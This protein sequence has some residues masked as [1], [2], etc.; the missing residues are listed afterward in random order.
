MRLRML[1]HW[2]T[3]R[4]DEDYLDYFS[5]VE[6]FTGKRCVGEITPSYALLAGEGFSDILRVMPEAKLFFIMRNPVA[7]V[8]SNAC[9]NGNAPKDLL[10][11]AKRPPVQLRTDYRRTVTALR[12]RVPP[13]RVHVAFYEDLSDSANGQEHLSRLFAHLGLDP[14]EVPEEVLSGR[15]KGDRP[16]PLEATERRELAALFVDA[17]TFAREL[18]GYLPA[19]W[20]RDLAALG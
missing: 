18:M 19:A 12:E 17:Y 11:F 5:A 4:S 6:R 20:E 8:W 7:R 16:E 13:E 14:Y 2:L 3:M 10:T 9:M 1:A 15:G